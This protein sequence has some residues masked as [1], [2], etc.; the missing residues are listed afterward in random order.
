[1]AKAAARLK[2]VSVR[3]VV[4]GVGFRPFVYRL[5]HDHQLTGWVLNHSG[6]VEIEVE[7]PAPALDAFVH[8]LT[9]QAPPLARI[10]AVEVSDAPPKGHSAFEIRHSV[11]QEGRYQLISP[12]IATCGDCLRELLD[13]GDR[14]YRYPFTNCTNCGPRFTI[15]RDIP[16]DRPLTTMQ[17][18]AMCPA[19]QREYDDP[20]DRRFHAQPN[21]CPVCGPHVWLEGVGEP[22]RRLAERDDAIRQAGAMLLAGKVLALKGLGGFHLACDATNG[23]ALGIL[24][25]R[26]GRPAK[27]L[28]VMMATLDD[29]RQ[30]CIVSDEEAGLLASQQCPIVLL[31]WRGES[32]VT[33]AVAPGNL[34]LGVML[35]YTPLHHV[36]LRDLGRP[37]VMTSGNLSEEPIAQTN[38]EA[39]RRLGPLADAFLMHNRDIYARYDDA[40]MF[41]VPC[42]NPEDQASSPQ[43]IRRSRGYAPFP[44]RLPFEAGQILAVGAELKNTFCLTRDDFAFL[45]QHIGDMENLETLEHFESSIALLQHL[46]RIEPKVIA[47]DLHPDYFS[48]KYAARNPQHALRIPVQHHEAHIAACL[49]DNGWGPDDGPVIGVAWD[50]TGYG[51]DG[52]I[53]GGEFFVGDYHGFKRAAHL[54]YLPL[55]GGDAAV[56]NPWRLALGYVYA[57]TGTVPDLPGVSEQAVRIVCQQVELGLNTPLT[58][59][60]GRLFDAVA[61]LAGVRHEVTY[62]AQAAIELEMLATLWGG[63]M[64]AE[65]GSLAYPFDLEHGD[66]V[67]VIRLRRLL[68]GIQDDL[69]GDRPP[70][71]I[72]WCFHHTMAELMI[73]VCQQLAR[74]RGL[75]TMALSG[76]CF[77]N[78]LLLGLAVPGLE[79]AGFR[80][81]L[82]RQVPC[83][84]GGISLGQAVLAHFEAQ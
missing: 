7:G 73:A 31:R 19:C 53:W 21:A 6:G 28:A 52:K 35:P 51:L 57:L 9:A 5:A 26:K 61:A 15:I 33:R 39:R 47:Y 49:A 68:E 22:G 44:V 67:V 75:L 23:A 1:M 55:A 29:V 59:A 37:L 69:A 3:G 8:D 80:V 18:F 25:G 32:T 79:R 77:Q 56:Y 82:H 11:A 12:D 71:E 38:D 42:G 64:Q 65:A 27:P 74:E 30:H 36:L 41:H 78:R 10:V 16:Y 58:S 70:A 34:Y 14:R 2:Q 17:P 72:G 60:A 45:S 48:T 54:E 66:D 62:E 43:P 13:P 81:L 83:N 40:V 20:L 46:F 24:R 84:D 50:G 63:G 4:Q 76:G